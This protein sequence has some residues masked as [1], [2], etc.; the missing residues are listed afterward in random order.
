MSVPGVQGPQAPLQCLGDVVQWGLTQAAM[1][2]PWASDRA[3]V[4]TGT[5]ESWGA[6]DLM[7][8]KSSLPIGALRPH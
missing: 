2:L 4:T 5:A 8:S 6:R 7:S 3:H 1:S